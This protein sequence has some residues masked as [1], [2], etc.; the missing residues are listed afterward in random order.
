MILRDFKVLSSD[1]INSILVRISA[2]IDSL[3]RYIYLEGVDMNLM[4]LKRQ[5]TLSG[6]NVLDLLS[7]IR[8]P[9][10]NAEKFAKTLKDIIVYFPKLNPVNDILNPWLYFH[11]EKLPEDQLELV[12]MYYIN[13]MNT[14][15]GTSYQLEVNVQNRSR[16]LKDIAYK[17]KEDNS[18]TETLRE[19]NPTSF[20]KGFLI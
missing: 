20:S 14:I 5:K 11:S 1:T 2:E 12:V 9:D 13:T 7:L 8:D 16:F 17:I 15:L 6:V 3:P 4:A 19:R 18:K 10:D